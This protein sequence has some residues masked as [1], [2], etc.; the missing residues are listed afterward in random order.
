VPEL[1]KLVVTDSEAADGTP[2]CLDTVFFL[3]KREKG[4]AAPRLEQMPAGESLAVLAANLY[5]AIAP[6]GEARRAELSALAK[7][8]AGI[9]VC[10]LVLP[11]DLDTLPAAAMQFRESVFS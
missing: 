9:R 6:D 3:D 4:L 1:K 7:V 8:A 10:R 11:D 2:A 5:G